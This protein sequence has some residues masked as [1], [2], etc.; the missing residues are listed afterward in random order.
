MASLLDKIFNRNK[1]KENKDVIK[2]IEQITPA[3]TILLQ[4][5]TEKVGVNELIQTVSVLAGYSCQYALTNVLRNNGIKTDK[6]YSEIGTAAN[7]VTLITN[8]DLNRP[9]FLDIYSV[10]NII[11]RGKENN[12]AQNIL[13][14]KN[15]VLLS[16]DVNYSLF[17]QKIGQVW[18]ESQ[19]F[20]Q[21]VNPNPIVWPMIYAVALLK[22]MDD[23]KQ[24]K[25]EDLLRVIHTV[26]YSS[27]LKIIM[28][29]T[30]ESIAF[31]PQGVPDF[32]IKASDDQEIQDKILI[33]TINKEKNNKPYIASQLMYKNVQ[34]KL[35]GTL[36]GEKGV[37]AETL[38]A[39]TGALTGYV[40]QQAVAEIY[41]EGGYIKGALPFMEIET[42]DGRKFFAGDNLNAFLAESKYSLWSFI[43]Q[44]AQSKGDQ[45][46]DIVEYFKY[47]AECIGNNDYGTLILPEDHPV[48]GNPLDYVLPMW[49]QMKDSILQYCPNPEERPLVFNLIAQSLMKETESLLSSDLQLKLILQ[50]AILSSKYDFSAEK[51]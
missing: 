22:A 14:V 1:V 24:T 2:T 15:E 4:I 43:A 39:V 20:V 47:S 25:N 10:W 13:K 44:V 29:V 18:R 19:S 48:I 33:D 46:P 36:N 11:N 42:K 23:Q 32:S 49:N 28:Q 8:E 37:H 38:L 51:A 50:S 12:S 9:L 40:I 6:A 5:L 7:N 35:M 21:T 26:F 16:N 17:I 41:K 3:S 45:L 34:Q 27:R 31:Y 30:E